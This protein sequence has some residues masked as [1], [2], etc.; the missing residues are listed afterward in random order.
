MVF[1]L[2]SHVHKNSIFLYFLL[3]KL[4]WMCNL[5][6][7]CFNKRRKSKKNAIGQGER[8][9]LPASLIHCYEII[10]RLVAVCPGIKPQEDWTAEK[11][12][13]IF[14][15][16]CLVRFLADS[17]LGIRQKELTRKFNISQVV[18]NLSVKHCKCEAKS[19]YFLL[20]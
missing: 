2:G 16:R 15:A 8:R 3:L 13:W 12:R 4:Y 19:K 11:H 6:K 7:P 18:V 20:I 1:L 5:Q 10:V 17:D 9:V 14:E